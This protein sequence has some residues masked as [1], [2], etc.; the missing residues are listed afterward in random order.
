VKKRPIDLQRV[1]KARAILDV[2]DAFFPEAYRGELP[3]AEWMG[4]LTDANNAMRES[5][6]EEDPNDE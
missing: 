3:Q 1:R 6:Q 4:V 5:P 2:V